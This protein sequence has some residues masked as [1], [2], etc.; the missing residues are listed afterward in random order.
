M[1]FPWQMEINRDL[2]LHDEDNEDRMASIDLSLSSFGSSNLQAEAGREWDFSCQ[3]GI[4]TFLKN[5][6]GRKITT[7]DMNGTYFP[8]WFDGKFHGSVSALAHMRW[9]YCYYI[10]NNEYNDKQRT[11]FGY[12][13]RNR[14]KTVHCL[15]CNVNLCPNCMN[16]WHGVDMRAA[17]RLLGQ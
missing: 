14:H 16:E 17:N 1:I 2:L 5:N 13:E 6:R 10:W 4:N 9:Q 3:E 8:H 11:D 7:G 12:R 15:V